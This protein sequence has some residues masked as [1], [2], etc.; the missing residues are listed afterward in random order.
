MWGQPA[1]VFQSLNIL[2]F[3][4]LNIPYIGPRWMIHHHNLG[5]EPWWCQ[6]APAIVSY[7]SE[8]RWSGMSRVVSMG[9]VRVE[10]YVRPSTAF[11]WLN[12]LYIGP[13]WMIQNHNLGLGSWWRKHAPAI[14]P[15]W[16][17]F[18]WRR[19]ASE[20]GNS[21]C[22]GICEAGQQLHRS[23]MDDKTPLP[24][25]WVMVMPPHTCNHPK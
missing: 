12:I 10:G 25:A 14:V 22:W 3:Q 1:I 7:W 6:H 8:F 4:W 18:R 24:G 21:G 23:R 5:L 9:I 11:Q 20:H 19:M 17:E 13:K 16:S 15:Y 2:A